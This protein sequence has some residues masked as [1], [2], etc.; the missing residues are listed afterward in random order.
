MIELLYGRAG[1][2][3]VLT[4]EKDGKEF[5]VRLRRVDATGIKWY[6]SGMPVP[7]TIPGKM[8]LDEQSVKIKMTE[9]GIAL[10]AISTFMDDSVPGKIYE[11]FDELRRAKGYIIDVRGNGGGNSDNAELRR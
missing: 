10:I 4:L 11:K 8:L 6:T 5:D 1:S 7:Q 9:D 3:V 2:E